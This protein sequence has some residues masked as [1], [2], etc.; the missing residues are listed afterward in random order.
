MIKAVVFDVGGTMHVS[1]KDLMLQESFSQQA[2]GILEEGGI[3]LDIKRE[4]FSACLSRQAEE[5]KAWSEISRRELP[6]VKIWGDYY[7]KPYNIDR[8]KLE[9]LAENLSFLYDYS[10][11]RLRRRPGL[12]DTM[13]KLLR[14]GL[15]LG[16]IS[17]IISKTFV[18]HILREYEIAQYMSCVVQSSVT[19]VRKPDPGIFRI[20]EN[21]LKMK[22][23]ELAY[24]GDTVSRDVIGTRKAGWRLMIQINNPSIAFRDNRVINSGFLP[25]YSIQRLDEIPAIISR[26][27]EKT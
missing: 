17:N 25:D 12:K 21:E 1:E 19:G 26:E 10:R 11:V 7:L 8:E 24:V 23:D 18:P 16:V 27:N 4:E 2:L 3:Q 22:P 13:V 5:Y 20:A 14:L 9:P 6:A 15:T